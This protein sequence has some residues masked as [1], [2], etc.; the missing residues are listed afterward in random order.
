MFLRHACLA[1]LLAGA[2]GTALAQ[3][4]CEAPALPAHLAGW[5]APVA[6]VAARDAASAQAAPLVPGQAVDLALAP[7]REVRFAAEPGKHPDPESHAGLA[8]LTVTKA[9]KYRV[10]ADSPVW[11]DVVAAG[12]PL[13]SAGHGHGPACSGIR[14]MVDFQLEPGRY[15]LQIA[16]SAGASAR[17]LVAALPAGEVEAEGS[18]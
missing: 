13:P 5:S 1:L 12:R 2:A 3:S 8:G 7:V 14:K 6:R 9:G 10:A 18:R 15:L 4:A 11:I 16:G 17:V